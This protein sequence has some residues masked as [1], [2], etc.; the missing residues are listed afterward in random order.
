VL[1]IG[2]SEIILPVRVR[3]REYRLSASFREAGED[4]L[5]FVHGLGSSKNNWRDAWAS[6]DLREK[7]LLAFDLIGFG[8]SP[9]SS[10]LDFTLEDYAE[11]LAGVIDAYAVRNIYV[12]AHSMGGTIALLLP[13]RTLTRIKNLILIEPRLKNSSCGFAAEAALG[14][15]RQFESELFPRY[16]QRMSG[17]RR[18][19]SD[20]DLA[21]PQAVYDSGRSLVRWT[22]HDEMLDRFQRAPCPKA[23]VYGGLNTHL[24]ELGAVDDRLK[25]EIPG[26]GHFAMHDEPALFYRQLGALLTDIP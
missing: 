3:A 18:A 7:S 16:R 4:L 2:T 8:H 21:D 5:V 25:F 11:L 14:D 22:R 24:E 17:N 26:A 23:F 20:L 9:R 1:V 19:T 10:G 6:R 12:V 13:Q 15:Y